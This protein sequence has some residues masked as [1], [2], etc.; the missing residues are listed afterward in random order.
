MDELYT[1][2]P[3]KDLLAVHSS[4]DFVAIGAPRLENMRRAQQVISIVQTLC[5]QSSVSTF[6]KLVSFSY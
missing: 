5:Q 4:V 2:K 3:D 1:S 6:H